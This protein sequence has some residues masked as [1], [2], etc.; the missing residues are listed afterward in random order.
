MAKK[1]KHKN[2]ALDKAKALSG[3]QDQNVPMKVVAPPKETIQPPPK[4]GGKSD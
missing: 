3:G 1:Q 2:P 4:L